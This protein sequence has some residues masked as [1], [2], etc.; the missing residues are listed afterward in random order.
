MSS[1]PPGW[2]YESTSYLWLRD[3]SFKSRTSLRPY[4]QVGPDPETETINLLSFS[5]FQAL[6]NVFGLFFIRQMELR[7]HHPAFVLEYDRRWRGDN[8]AVGNQ[9]GRDSEILGLAK[10]KAGLHV[11]LINDGA[12]AM[13]FLL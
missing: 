7:S 10:S 3:V 8:L 13:I 4:V 5:R 9:S 6:L 1:K 12:D 2:V 11:S